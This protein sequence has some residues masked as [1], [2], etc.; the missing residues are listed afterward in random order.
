MPPALDAMKPPITGTQL[1]ASSGSSFACMRSLVAA[2]S[3]AARVKAESVIR[4]SRASTSSDSIPKAL[5]AAATSVLE[6]ISP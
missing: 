3:G 4:H 2:K 6:Q 1:R 5:K